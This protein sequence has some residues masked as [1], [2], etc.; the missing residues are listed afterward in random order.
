MNW[1]PGWHSISGTEWWSN[2]YFWIGICGLMLLGFSELISHRYALRKDE[3]VAEQ[4]NDAQ[5]G[6]DQEIARL[7]LEAAQANRRSEELRADN[8]AL[9]KIVLPRRLGSTIAITSPGETELPPLASVQFAALKP[10]AGTPVVIQVVPD[11]EAYTL[12]NDIRAVLASFGWKSQIIDEGTS[13]VPPISI[14]EG[15]T[16]IYPPDSQ[17]ADAA[18]ALAAGFAKAGL[19]GSLGF[20]PKAQRYPILSD[21]T[22]VHPLPYPRFDEPMDA[23]IVMVGMK[24]MPSPAMDSAGR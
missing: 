20:A 14:A 21:G 22:P 5:S 15:V 17:Y 19:A 18:D 4:E 23:V 11:F 6:H 7:A 16:V 2:F 13:H 12:A 24:P 10:F 9:Q 1:M 8:L 3:L